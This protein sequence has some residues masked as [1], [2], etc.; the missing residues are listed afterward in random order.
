MST[1]TTPS[2]SE[3][4][5][6]ISGT[7]LHLHFPGVTSIDLSGLV[8]ASQVLSQLLAAVQTMETTMAALDDA[9]AAISA[10]QTTEDAS[11][12]ALITEISTA[13]TAQQAQVTALVAQVATLQ[14]AITAN[15]DVAGAVATLTTTTADI[16]TQGAK[17]DAATSALAGVVTPPAPPAGP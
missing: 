9:V 17:L 10:A 15:G 6:T 3:D 1:A 5:V 12:Q 13:T 2:T 14:A 7:H 16:Q 11:V 4:T 8:G